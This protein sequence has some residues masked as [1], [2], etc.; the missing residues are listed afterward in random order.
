MDKYTNV[1]Y[2]MDKSKVYKFINSNSFKNMNKL[3]NELYEVETN[4]SCVTVD[5]PLQI[6]FFYFTIYK[7]K[8]VRILL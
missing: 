2:L 5:T 4:K 3:G 8:D 1:K 7:I 6:G